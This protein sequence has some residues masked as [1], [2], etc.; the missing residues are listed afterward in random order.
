M[1]AK[2]VLTRAYRNLLRVC[3]GRGWGRVYPFNRLNDYLTSR[4]LPRL[5]TNIATVHGHR[6]LLDPLDSLGLSIYGT[7][8]PFETELIQS[9]VHPGDVVVDVGANIGY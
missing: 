4:V 6:M 9:L 1:I 2:Q 5:R 3:G 8:E 7:W